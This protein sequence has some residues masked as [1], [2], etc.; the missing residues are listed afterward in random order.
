M[1]APTDSFGVLCPPEE[2]D[3]RT[4]AHALVM[5]GSVTSDPRGIAWYDLVWSP[6]P[7]ARPDSHHALLPPQAE[8]RGNSGRCA[9][10]PPPQPPPDR[11]RV[12]APPPPPVPQL[13]ITV[14]HGR[15]GAGL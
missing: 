8:V 11:S 1:Y 10:L 13:S 12:C 9:V 6:P 5:L 2:K 4:M 15:A 3:S 7:D 14:L